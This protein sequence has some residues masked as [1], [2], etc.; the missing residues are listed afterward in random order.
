MFFSTEVAE[1][2]TADYT[3]INNSNAFSI[4]LE[5]NRSPK[6]NDSLRVLRIIETKDQ[7]LAAINNF[8]IDSNGNG[9]T[10]IDEDKIVSET[11]AKPNYS[12]KLDCIL[13]ESDSD[14]SRVCSGQL[15]FEE[16]FR[17]NI[18]SNNWTHV[19]YSRLYT[20][21]KEFAAF[22]KDKA[23]CYVRNK[24][25]YL[26]ATW[27]KKINQLE[28][29]NYTECTY[30]KPEEKTFLCGP[31]AFD[32]LNILP[33]VHSAAITTKATKLFKYGKIEIRAKMPVGDWLF[34]CE[35]INIF[36]LLSILV[37]LFLYI[38]VVR[39]SYR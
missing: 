29:L 36:K 15:I 39:F 20:E 5:G 16:S 1:E 2:C 31:Y 6:E 12:D 38:T 14:K 3:Y 30:K 4:K 10:H 21:H 24:K 26:H 37:Q 9:N 27:P 13:A 23:N 7:V 28:T 22:K 18:L 34:P 17:D 35:Y 33:P 8:Q 11:C 32:I 19:Q 25:L